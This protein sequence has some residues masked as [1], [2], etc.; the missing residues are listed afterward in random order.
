M[1]DENFSDMECLAV[2]GVLLRQADLLALTVLTVASL[3][4]SVTRFASNTVDI[5]FF[6]LALAFASAST[7]LTRCVRR[8]HPAKRALEVVLALG[9]LG[10]ILYGYFSTGSLML[11]ALTVFVAVLMLMGFTLSYLLPKICRKGKV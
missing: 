11:E 10:T 6:G 7:A 5:G 2:M 4:L 1:K 3:S 9:A 8:D